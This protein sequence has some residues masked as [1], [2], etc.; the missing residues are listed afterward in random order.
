LTIAAGRSLLDLPIDSEQ[1]SLLDLWCAHASI[2]AASS[3]VEKFAVRLMTNGLKPRR[4]ATSE[5]VA[6]TVEQDPSEMRGTGGVLRDVVEDYPDDSFIA[7]ANAAQ[8]LND[9][10]PHLLSDLA[11]TGADV[12]LVAHEDGTPGGIWLARCGSL[13]MI[14]PI[15]Y[16]DMKEQALPLIARK[17]NVRVIRRRRPIGSPV[18]MHRDYIRALRDYHQRVTQPDDAQRGPFD[19]DCSPAFSLCESGAE[20]HP[21]ARLLDSVVLRGGRVERGAVVARSVVGPRGVV[22]HGQTVVDQL[23]T[24]APSLLRSRGLNLW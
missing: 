11:A 9:S 18:R 21:T 5:M 23:V 20:V 2:Q 19:E 24:A 16:V 12:A 17:S 13:R 1:H 8:I 15:G 3:R 4:T 7:V 10:M 14:S 6:F 22:R